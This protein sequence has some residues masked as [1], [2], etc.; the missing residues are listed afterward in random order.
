M[1]QQLATKI[2][3]LARVKMM[4][5]PVENS[6]V[7]QIDPQ[8]LPIVADEI[9]VQ[10]NLSDIVAVSLQD[11]SIDPVT[12]ARNTALEEKPVQQIIPP[13]VP[14]GLSPEQIK[15]IAEGQPDPAAPKNPS[16]IAPIKD[17]SLQELQV[18]A[19]SCEARLEI[20]ERRFEH[21]M[22]ENFRVKY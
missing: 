11:H 12:A 13:N 6:R 7:N 1:F 17:M 18:F 5:D 14:D 3:D 4:N 10:G 16:E 2:R 8:Q 22:E 15:S 9:R 19:L 21:L 20:L